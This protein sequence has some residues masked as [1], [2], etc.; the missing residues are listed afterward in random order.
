TA[1]QTPPHLSPPGTCWGLQP[2]ALPKCVAHVPCTLGPLALLLSVPFPEPAF[3]GD[4][5]PRGLPLSANRRA[6]PPSAFHRPCNCQR[7][8]PSQCRQSSNGT[9]ER[10]T[11][12]ISLCLYQHGENRRERAPT[13]QWYQWNRPPGRGHAFD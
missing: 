2:A 8:P 5:I 11:S 1:G 9:R 10:H 13:C 3:G 12:R 4:R 6:C 7:H